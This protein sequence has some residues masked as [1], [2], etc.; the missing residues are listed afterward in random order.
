[1]YRACHFRSTFNR[2]WTESPITNLKEHPFC[3]I[4]VVAR[5][6]AETW[7]SQRALIKV[8]VKQ[9]HYRAWQALRVPGGWGSQIL[10]QSAHEVGKVVSTTHRPPLSQEMFLVLISV[11]GWVDPRAIVQPKGLCQWKKS[12]D[13]I[14]NRTGDLPVCRAVPQ[15]LRHR[16]PQRALIKVKVKQS[17]YRAWQALRVPGGW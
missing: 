11:R 5:G 16:V 17:H 15:P 10:R 7:R 3:G 1:V 13:T 6:K 9:S 8:K 14:G 12:T 4:R 2:N